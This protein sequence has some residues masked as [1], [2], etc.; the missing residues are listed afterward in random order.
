[1][2]IITAMALT[3]DR[4]CLVAA[5]HYLLKL[6]RVQESGLPPSSISDSSLCDS[7]ECMKSLLS[8]S[9]GLAPKHDI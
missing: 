6:Q 8:D 4:M 9:E 1:M 7:G 5:L 2:L 3:K